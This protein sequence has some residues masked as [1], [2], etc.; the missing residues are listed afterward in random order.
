MKDLTTSRGSNPLL[1]FRDEMENF[2]DRFSREL[3]LSDES[4]FLPRVEVRDNGKNFLVSAELPGM[5]EK[6][7]NLSLD[8]NT[9]I[10]EGERKNESKV[11]E[12][13][14]YR[15]EFSYGSFYRAIPLSSEVNPDKVM[16]NYENGVLKV[17]LDKVAE[18]KVK[19]K[20]I[21]IGKGKGLTH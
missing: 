21:E 14:Y 7:I 1:N 9:L 6:D 20:K 13:D 19:T 5:T 3:S 12:K 11:E 2:F 8:N 17:T 18:S 4:N 15:S 16:A 10:I